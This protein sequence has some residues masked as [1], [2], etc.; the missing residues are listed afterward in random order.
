MTNRI[1]YTDAPTDVDEALDEATIV[2]D[3][4]PSTRSTYPQDGKREDHYCNR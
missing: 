1:S 4:L 2:A 3:L